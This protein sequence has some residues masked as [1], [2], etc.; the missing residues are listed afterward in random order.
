MVVEI[1][2]H[3]ARS[4]MFSYYD[5]DDWLIES[6]SLTTVGMRQHYLIGRQLRKLYIEQTPLISAEFNSSEIFILCKSAS[7]TIMSAQS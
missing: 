1:S 6:A 5:G 4:P 3:G 7:R 2:R